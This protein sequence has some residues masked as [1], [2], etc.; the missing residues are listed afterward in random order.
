MSK[1]A[2]STS[3]S[4]WYPTIQFNC[5]IANPSKGEK[6]WKS[7]NV[8][9]FT[10]PPPGL[11]K[12]SSKADEFSITHKPQADSDFAEA[13]TIRANL[14][15]DLQVSLEFKRPATAPGFK[16]GKGPKG[17]YSYFG[18]DIEKPEGYVIHR[19]WPMLSLS[20]Q[21]VQSGKAESVSGNGMFVHAIQG[22]RPN[23]VASAWNFAHFD[24][25]QLGGVSAIQMEFTTLDT[26][27]KRGSGSGKVAVNIG[28]VVIGGK[29]A[30]VTAQTKWPGEEHTGESISSA[31][32]LKPQTD[33]D[34]SYGKP[35]EIEYVWKGPS[36]DPAIPGVIESRLTAHVGSVEE[37]KGLV[38][39]VDVLAEIPYALKMVVN[40]VAGTKPYI[41]QVSLSLSCQRPSNN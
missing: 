40:Y 8:T 25:E 24:S 34:T 11:D 17:G 41:Y 13:Y 28:S 38:E 36:V 33:P 26:H 9:N 19:F 4:V 21:I 32:H 6:V 22:M 3:N 16:V 30:M 31:T 27:G 35:T 20:G 2:Y 37:P 29:L 5:K 7:I 39:K 14:G 10:C 23:L 18:P 1:S 15:T 12:H